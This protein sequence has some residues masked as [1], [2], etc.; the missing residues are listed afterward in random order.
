MSQI[1]K[2]L[3]DF[4]TLNTNC[5]ISFSGGQDSIS[6]IILW[7]N[8]W[9]LKNNFDKKSKGSGFVWCH[10]LWKKQ[11]FFLLR[12]SY[13]IYFF[14][15]QRF[16]FTVL[17]SKNF[18]EQEA[19][20]SRYHCFYRILKYANFSSLITVHTKTDKIETFF[21]HLFRGS[22]PLGLQNIR[23]YQKFLPYECSQNF[24]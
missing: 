19:R 18:R 17:F 10:H 16:F 5:L 11:D 3:L 24:R 7:I 22:G 12:H 14:F 21:L 4:Q 6:F 15:H 9:V 8:L 20:N 23:S 13:Q 1:E 2:I